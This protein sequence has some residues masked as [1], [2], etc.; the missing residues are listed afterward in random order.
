MTGVSPRPWTLTAAAA[1][2]FGLSVVVAVTSVRAA[3]EFAPHWEGVVIALGFGG[4]FA[5][6]LSRA[7]HAL[8]RQSVV[9]YLFFRAFVMLG[10]L[11]VMASLASLL[12]A[13]AHGQLP[14]EGV[15]LTAFPA[16][17]QSAWLLLLTALLNAPR[18]RLALDLSPTGGGILTLYVDTKVFLVMAVLAVGLSASI[19]WAVGR[20][21]P[22]PDAG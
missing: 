17:A 20:M 22:T 1:L 11:G 14:A 13:V 12:V 5:L 8:L 6:A 16:V 3:I 10:L 7:A 9:T 21:I 4:L 19:F 15:L 2:T 18:T